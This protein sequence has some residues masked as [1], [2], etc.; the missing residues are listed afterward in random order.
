[1]I[2]AFVVAPTAALRIGLSARLSG[3]DITVVGAGPA[4]E[5]A[6]A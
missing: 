1:M 2:R 6:P 4:L 5:D 3:A